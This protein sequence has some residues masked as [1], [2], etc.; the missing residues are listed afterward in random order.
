[1]NLQDLGKN[2]AVVIGLVIVFIGGYIY[3]RENPSRMEKRMEKEKPEYLTEEFAEAQRLEADEEDKKNAY[4]LLQDARGY[5]E[6][7]QYREARSAFYRAIALYPDGRVYYEYARYLFVMN[8]LPVMKESLALAETFGF[9]RG[10]ICFEKARL[11][12][13]LKNPEES[14]EYL[15][16]AMQT[17]SFSI[18]EIEEEWAFDVIRKSVVTKKKYDAFINRIHEYSIEK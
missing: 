2:R 5:M 3:I 4:Q 12:G 18:E 16:Q 7:R 11:Y 1:M 6:S 13:K 9:D 15:Q 14:L 17:G 10:L 8:D